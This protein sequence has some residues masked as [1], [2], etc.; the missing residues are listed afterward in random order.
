MAFTRFSSPVLVARLNNAGPLEVI[1]SDPK[2][3]NARGGWEPSRT[4]QLIVSP[5]T[6]HTINGRI[7]NQ[8]GEA[9][10]TIET[11]RVYVLQRLFVSDGNQDADVVVYRGRCFKVT[12][13]DDYELAGEVFI[14][15]A[16]L[17][18]PGR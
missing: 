3:Q 15:D 16:E 2:E 6:V 9:N 5:A 10:R 12:V 13:V 17:G 18:E 14:C 8:V 4:R 7:L 1:R 11:I